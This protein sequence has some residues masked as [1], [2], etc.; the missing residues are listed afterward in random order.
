MVNG[1]G[2]LGVRWK[3]KRPLQS[4][5][6]LEDVY[7]LASLLGSV[8][9]SDKKDKW[10]WF[11]DGSGEFSVGAVKKVIMEGRNSPPI[12]SFKW[13]KWIPVK[14]NIFAWR[15]SLNRIPTVEALSKRNVHVQDSHC[16]FCIDGEDNVDHLFI[17]CLAANSVWNA[18]SGWCRIPP[19]FAFSFQDLMETHLHSGL[20]EPEKSILQGLVIIACWS[21][22]KA[23]NDARFRS[24]QVRIER[25]ISEVKSVG[26]L[27]VRNRTKF[28]NLTWEDWCKFV[29]M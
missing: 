10:G 4:G 3:W 9:L 24:T 17:Q 15:A 28:R 12:S 29:I 25:I 14:C 7:Q 20:K 13:C 27:W 1:P 19:I 18:I 6:E 11:G 5:Q 2:Q 16:G 22:W 23:R 26:Y 21:I 8:R